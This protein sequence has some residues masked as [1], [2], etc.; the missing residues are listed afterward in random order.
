MNA[1]LNQAKAA[2]ET[3]D[4]SVAQTSFVREVAPAGFTVARFIGYVEVGKQPQRAFEG[5]EKADAAEVRLTFELLGP[6]HSTEYEKDGVKMT[7]TNTIRQKVT[8]S[9]NEKAGFFKLMKKMIG[10]RDGIKHMAEMLGEGFLIKISHN[11]SKDGKNTYANM[12]S[13]GVWDISAPI[14]T[15][16]ITNDVRVLEVPEATQPIQ[17]LL[18]DTP[19]KD[20]WDSIFIDGEYEKEVDGVKVVTSKNFVQEEAMSASNFVGSPLE[21]FL[22]GGDDIVADM[23]TPSTTPATVA[24]TATAD[25]PTTPPAASSDPLAALGL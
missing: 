11:K 18:W 16:P 2:A 7:R 10:G 22:S 5:V 17:L 1:L 25:L 4:Q 21:A 3:T 23:L 8:V 15:D 9:L 6:K 20:Q 12:K 24:A 19:S 13:D 14:A